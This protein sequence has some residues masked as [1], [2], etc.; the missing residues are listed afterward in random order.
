MKAPAFQWY[1][2]E[3]DTDEN[4]R[5]MDDREFGFYVRCLNHSWINDGLPEDL[6]ELARVMQ[7]PAGYVRRIWERVGRCF[8]PDGNRLRNPKQESQRQE[9]QRF[10]ESRRSAA[11]TRWAK[12]EDCKTDARALHVECPASASSPASAEE[13]RTPLT[14]PAGGADPPAALALVPPPVKAPRK[15]KP[16]P[17]MTAEQRERFGEF[18]GIHPKNTV[19]VVS[20]EK[21]W[22]E[23][24]KDGETADWL[25]AALRRECLGDTT[26]MFGPGKW[27]ADHLALRAN[28]AT[29]NYTR[30][31]P[32]G[33]PYLT[34]SEFDRRARQPT[35][36]ERAVM[37]LFQREQE[38]LARS[39]S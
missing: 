2:K 4:V 7:R 32:E 37:E 23:K 38:R 34:A 3:C 25:I 26:F 36:G 18:L 20:A 11:N 5:G 8:F 31:R 22:A 15:K 39:T 30:D 29:A 33:S 1:P 28:G 13:K 21:L 9:Y 24:V 16:E 35:T 10:K 6:G 17:T 27:L 12:Q 19:Q 14:P